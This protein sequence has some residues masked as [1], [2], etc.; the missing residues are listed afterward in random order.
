MPEIWTL[1]EKKGSTYKHE[2]NVRDHIWVPFQIGIPNSGVFPLKIFIEAPVLEN[3]AILHLTTIRFPITNCTEFPACV[4]WNSQ[5]DTEKP[6][7]NVLGVN[8]WVDIERTY[9]LEKI[10]SDRISS[11][12]QRDQIFLDFGFITNAGFILN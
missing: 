6:G 11:H 2:G 4:E 1:E 9:D 7:M 10:K 3:R 12:M 5:G 8:H